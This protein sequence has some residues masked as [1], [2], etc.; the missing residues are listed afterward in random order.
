MRIEIQGPR[1]IK[2]SETCNIRAV[3]FNDSFEPVAVSR[4]ALIGPTASAPG[5]H[6]QPL[7][8]EATYG[9]ADQPLTLQ[10]FTFYG[11]ERAFS[12][13][14]PGEVTITASYGPPD[15]PE[16]TATEHMRIEPG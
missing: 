15:K 6:P 9:A 10:P 14:L 5:G 8:V 16:I 3:L 12:G 11:R 1:T 13:L 7:A 4:N 2:E